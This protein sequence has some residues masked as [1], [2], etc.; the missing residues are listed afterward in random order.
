MTK[1]IEK[2]RVGKTFKNNGMA[3]D[4]KYYL[5]PSDV[6]DALHEIYG[7]GAFEFQELPH[8][9]SRKTGIIK[10]GKEE[11]YLSVQ[12]IRSNATCFVSHSKPEVFEVA[13]RGIISLHAGFHANG[14]LSPIWWIEPGDM[15]AGLSGMTTFSNWNR[16]ETVEKLE[17]YIIFYG[18]ILKL[19][20]NQDELYERTASVVPEHGLP[21]FLPKI[22]Q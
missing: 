9:G 19:L 5:L 10:I 15:Y 20:K 8:G 1:G 22:A 4:K 12:H 2:H 14:K 16:E 6:F 7:M 17:L 11:L 21:S 13:K 3:E 18:T